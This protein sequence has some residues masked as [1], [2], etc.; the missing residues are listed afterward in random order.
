MSSLKQYV[1]ECDEGEEFT[2]K[3]HANATP[4]YFKVVR[5]EEDTTIV[6]EKRAD[7]TW[8]DEQKFNPYAYVQ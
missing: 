7:G 2:F 1:A 6:L 8:S 3:A 5:H 4:Q